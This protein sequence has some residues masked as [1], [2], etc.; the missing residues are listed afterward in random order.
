MWAAGLFF[1]TLLMVLAHADMILLLLHTQQEWHKFGQTPTHVQ[2]VFQIFLN[3][4]MWNSQH[5]S[6]FTGSDYF[7]CKARV[8][9]SI[10]I[11]ICFAH[12]S[13]FQ[14]FGIFVPCKTTL[15][16]T[17]FSLSALPKA[18]LNISKVYVAFFLMLHSFF[19]VS[20]FSRYVKIKMRTHVPNKTFLN[21]HTCYSLF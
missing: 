18:T 13:T 4:S 17:F 6:N 15:K 16:F 9:H 7:V 12:R 20:H 21:N 14:V 10:H 1:K 5:V 3:W 11:F 19:Q 8:L 2:T